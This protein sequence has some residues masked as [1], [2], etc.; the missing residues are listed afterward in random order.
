[1]YGYNTDMTTHVRRL[2][3]APLKTER[4]EMRLDGDILTRIDQWRSQQ[5]DLP[6]RAE[7]MRRLVETGLSRSSPEAITFRPPRNLQIPRRDHLPCTVW[8]FL[9]GGIITRQYSIQVYDSIQ[10]RQPLHFFSFGCQSV[11]IVICN[12]GDSDN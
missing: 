7:A 8:H 10:F 11:C 2:Q 3:N 4:F 1:M 5:S 6:A 12:Q 9:S